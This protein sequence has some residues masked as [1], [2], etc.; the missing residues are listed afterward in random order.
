MSANYRY[1][2]DKA[3]AELTNLMEQR[4]KLDETREALHQ[5]IMKL[6]SA[7]RGLGSLCDVENVEEEYRSL[8]PDEFTDTDVGLTDAIRKVL[9]SH[10]DAYLSPVFI[11]DRLADVGFDIQTHKNILASIHTVLKRLQRQGEVAPWTREGRTA[12]KWSP[13]KKGEPQQEAELSDDD[14]PF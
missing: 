3:I 4:E 7:V 2:L 14:I 10:E 9:A 11:R 8:F 12:Y 13:K 1:T 5:R 6:R